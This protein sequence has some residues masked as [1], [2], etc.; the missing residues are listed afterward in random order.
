ME[1]ENEKIK[2]L[3]AQQN[4][5]NINISISQAEEGISNLNKNKKRNCHQY[6]EKI[7]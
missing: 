3:Q 2:Y 1:L 6:R 7:K 4:L 5:E